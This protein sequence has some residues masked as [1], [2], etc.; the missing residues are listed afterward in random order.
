MVCLLLIMTTLAVYSQV[1]HHGFINYDDDDYV[2]ENPRVQAGWTME[3]LTWAITTRFHGH[4]HP[5]TWLSHMTDYQLFGLNPAGHHL[6]SVFLHLANT[7]LLFFVLNRMTRA[8]LRS[9]LV[10]AMF[11]LHPLHVEPVAWVAD[12]KDILSAFFWMVTMGVYVHYAAYPGFRRYLLVLI[13]FVLGLMA[14]PMVVTLPLVLLLMDY[15]PLERLEFGESHKGRRRGKD[16]SLEAR[17]QSA[18][19][20]RLLLEKGLFFFILGAS[21]V[22]TVLAMRFERTPGFN[23]SDFQPTAADMAKSLA[24]YVT[25]MGK[26][27]WPLH[28]ATPYPTLTMPSPWQIVGAFLLLA[29]ISCWVIWQRRRYPYLLVGWLWYLITLLPVIGLVKVGPHKMADRYVYIPLVG[30]FV[31]VAWGVPDLV[32]GWRHRRLLVGISAS[33]LVLGLAIGSWLQLRHWKDSISLFGHTVTVTSNNS[34]AH[35]NLG[36]AYAD[37]GNFE[38][39]MGHYREA[40]RIEPDYAMA[41]FNLGVALY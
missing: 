27:L 24:L 6:S 41:L 2:T 33:V 5:V 3:S 18:P 25:Y 34:L 17:Y 19:A 36:T 39:A 11:A 7:L 30:L 22:V 28:L 21:A 14:K 35:N 40:I 20:L 15:W 12:R 16:K 32:K 13:P 8:L 26:M 1:R 23:L 10:A 31:M 9:A 4:W 29:G 37:Q 38:T